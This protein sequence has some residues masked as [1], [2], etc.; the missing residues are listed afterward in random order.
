MDKKEKIL[1]SDT[2]EE[3]MR[4]AYNIKRS[5]IHLE[6]LTDE[7][8]VRIKL[9]IQ[10]RSKSR[11]KRRV[12]RVPNPIIEVVVSST[13]CKTSQLSLPFKT[14]SDFQCNFNYSPPTR[15]TDSRRT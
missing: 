15:S 12:H 7:D 4:N 2:F 8:I 5:Q 10:R 9:E 6:K 1:R 11:T 14:K 13:D 3:F